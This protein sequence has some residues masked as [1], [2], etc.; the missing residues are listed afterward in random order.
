MSDPADEFP[1]GTKVDH[2]VHGKGV[3]VGDHSEFLQV[4]V[5]FETGKRVWVNPDRLT[6]LSESDGD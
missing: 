6:P 3:V 4:L 1:A 2:L 5:E